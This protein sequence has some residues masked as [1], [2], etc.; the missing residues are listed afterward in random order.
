ML[1]VS[2]ETQTFVDGPRYQ[3]TFSYLREVPNDMET[4]RVTLGH[5]VEQERIR[6][7]IQR[8]VIQE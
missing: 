6:I 1:R 7:V 3:Q 4:A 5:D 2:Q 8:L